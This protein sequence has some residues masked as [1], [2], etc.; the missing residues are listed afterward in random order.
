[1]SEQSLVEVLRSLKEEAASGTEAEDKLS[2]FRD[3]TY[4]I[5]FVFDSSSRTF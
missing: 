1:M 3:G 4:R 2:A 5:E